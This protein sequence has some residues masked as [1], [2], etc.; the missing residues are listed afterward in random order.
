MEKYKVKKSIIL[1]GLMEVSPTCD[2]YVNISSNTLTKCS[3]YFM[4]TTREE[5]ENYVT[6]HFDEFIELPNYRKMKY[7]DMVYDY[8]NTINNNEII[9]KAKLIICNE[10]FWYKE[11]YNILNE[12]NLKDDFN[13]YRYERLKVVLEEIIVNNSHKI[14]VIDDLK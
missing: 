14:E 8:V 6:E 13:K 9:H 7:Y 1:D 3:L 4:S 12:Y 11:F 5:I 10:K 2:V